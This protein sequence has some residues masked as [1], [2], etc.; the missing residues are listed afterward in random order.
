MLLLRF[1]GKHQSTMI[2][3]ERFSSQYRSKLNRLFTILLIYVLFPLRPRSARGDM[4]QSNLLN[5]VHL[6]LNSEDHCKHGRMF[7]IHESFPLIIQSTFSKFLI[8]RPLQMPQKCKFKNRSSK[9]KTFSVNTKH[10]YQCIQNILLVRC[11]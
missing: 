8:I 9:C 6:H 4:V 1:G 2:A 10:L 3:A 5:P 11:N 7:S